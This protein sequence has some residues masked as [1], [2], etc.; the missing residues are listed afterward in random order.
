MERI[1]EVSRSPEGDIVIRLCPP[2][3]LPGEV[4]HHLLGVSREGLLALRSL[5]DVALHRVEEAE[6]KEAGKKG[7]TKIE[8]Q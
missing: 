3:P 8:V 5:L 4:R 6:K 1:L 7:P 2:R